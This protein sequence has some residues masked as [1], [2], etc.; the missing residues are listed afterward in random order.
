M[1]SSAA[2][3][4]PLPKLPALPPRTYVDA[5]RVWRWRPDG[6]E[7]A[8]FGVN[9][10]TPFAYAYRAHHPLGANVERAIA[11][12]VYHFARLGLD[13]F[14]VHVWDVEISDTLGNLLENEHLRLLDY[15]VAQLQRRGI[16]VVLTPIAYWNNGY[17][18]K[19]TGTGFSSRYPK[20][21][22]YRNP[23]AV[24]AQERYLTQFLNHRNVYTGQLLKDDPAISG[25]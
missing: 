20:D 4:P 5:Q 22:A 19:D 8:L 11:Q 1:A 3:R 2:A 18:E 13:A 12:D 10:T 16:A 9:Y 21:A 17:P 7:V 25:V 6:R 14:R 15:L 24:A 23:R